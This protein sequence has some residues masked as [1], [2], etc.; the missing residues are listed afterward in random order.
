MPPKKPP[1]IADTAVFDVGGDS[2][3]WQRALCY[4]HCMYMDDIGPVN[5]LAE[6]LN[7]IIANPRG[8]MKH[9]DIIYRHGDVCIRKHSFKYGD[10]LESPDSEI[11]VGACRWIMRNMAIR[12]QLRAIVVAT[13]YADDKPIRPRSPA[14]NPW[15]VLIMIK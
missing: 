1:T 12:S 9:G 5:A 10:I 6:M 13:E 11:I 4:E 2:S 15:N 8:M 3:G 14:T 7:I